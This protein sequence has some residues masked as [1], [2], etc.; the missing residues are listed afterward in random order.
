MSFAPAYFIL[1]AAPEYFLT[2]RTLGTFYHSRMEAM[3]AADQV[4]ALLDTPVTEA[5][6]HRRPGSGTP[7]RLS[8]APS[9]A[10]NDVSFSYGGKSVLRSVPFMILPGEHVALT[11]ESGAGKSTILSLLIRFASAEDGTITVDERRSGT[12]TSGWRRRVAWLPQ[13]PTLFLGTIREN[14]LLGRRNAQ[15][16]S[17]AKRCRGSCVEEFLPRLSGGIDTRIGEGGQ[18]LSGGQI[19]R[20]ALA[21]LFLR[22]P[23]LVLLDEPTAHLDAESAGLVA[24][25]VAVLFRG[26]T[27]VLVTHKP[28]TAGPWIGCSSCE[29]VLWRKPHEHAHRLLRLLL[30]SWRMALLGIFLSLLALL[31]NMALLALSS[32]FITSMADCRRAA[33]LHG[34][35]APRNGGARTR[36]CPCRGQIR[37]ALR[38][39]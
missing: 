13:R 37:G 31:A 7:V 8:A 25:G 32:W 29:T 10:F 23:P 14:I 21:R 6:Y 20:V 19:Q 39:S 12:S 16:G 15:N 22:D 28:M 11:G 1:L 18:G 4:R 36:P 30:P 3:S 27:T 17:S 38:Q 33:S 26:R 2:L 35:H 24:G 9:V 5:V 34:V